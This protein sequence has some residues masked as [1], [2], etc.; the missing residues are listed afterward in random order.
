MNLTPDHPQPP[1]PEFVDLVQR[2]LDHEASLEDIARL[3]AVLP[4]DPAALR[5]FVKMRLLHGALEKEFGAAS[6]ELDSIDGRSTTVPPGKITPFP[7][8][9]AG[10]QAGRGWRFWAAAAA[11]A[12]LASLAAI[13]GGHRILH[14]PAFEI[15]ARTGTGSSSVPATGTWLGCGERLTLA[16]GAV[17]LRSADGNLLTLQ[18][19]GDLTIRDAHALT[20]ASGKLWAVLKGDPI[21]IGTPQGV[22]TDLG[23]TFGI[24]QSSRWSTRLDV[25]DG[26]AQ[27]ADPADPSRSTVAAPGEGLIRQGTQWPPEKHKADASR[28]TAGIRRPLGLAFVKNQAEASR[29]ESA[30]P[31][32]AQ[33]TSV[34]TPTGKTQPKGASFEI[35]WA[36]S[37]FFSA[38]ADQSPEAALFHTHLSGYAWEGKYAGRRQDAADL[39]LPE[40]PHGIVIQLRGMSAWL[41]EIGA[42]SYRITLLRNSGDPGIEFLPVSAYDGQ[43]SEDSYLAMLQLWD[44]DYLAA[45]FP[46]APGGTG[47]RAI[48]IFKNPFTADLLTLTLPV[49]KSQTWR[50][51]ISGLIVTP[52]F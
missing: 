6:A 14:R 29:I 30:F 47:A 42:K 34:S 27:L 12:L 46:D 1:A 10:N 35:A 25:F 21:R 43:A 8:R 3:N 4:S 32:S 37:S 51:N 36:G 18:G 15:V 40:S 44:K 5:Y 41:A 49:Q 19:P 39:G 52:M 26:K 28:Y 13:W 20:L 16:Q 38:G 2:V 11:V 23:T 7:G 45:N 24:D 22:V 31:F 9:D 33:W 17:E 48:G 50:A